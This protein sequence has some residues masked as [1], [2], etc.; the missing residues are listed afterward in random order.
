MAH[1][2]LV[3]VTLNTAGGCSNKR[4][5]KQKEHNRDYLTH[6][7][8]N[9]IKLK[10][11]CSRPFEDGRALNLAAKLQLRRCA[12]INFTGPFCKKWWLRAKAGFDQAPPPPQVP[13]SPR[14]PAASSTVKLRHFDNPPPPNVTVTM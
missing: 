14:P 8:D 9:S 13:H 7:N 4:E 6:R 3:L 2:N 10:R 12:R 5:A 11:Q 1:A